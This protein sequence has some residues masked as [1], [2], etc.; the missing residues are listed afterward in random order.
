MR[1]MTLK[2][3]T[4]KLQEEDEGCRSTRRRWWVLD[5]KWP[6]PWPSETRSPIISNSL[7]RR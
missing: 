4:A 2:K 6:R 5:G 1:E 3:K 7:P